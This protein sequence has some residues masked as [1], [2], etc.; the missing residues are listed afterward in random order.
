MSDQW[1][2]PPIV[3]GD[4]DTPAACGLPVFSSP[5]S[6]S[7]KEYVFVQ[8]WMCSRKAF[9]FT[10]LDTPH[11]SASQLPDYSA[12]VL[13]EEGPRGDMGGGMVK[14]NR[15][16]AIVP[17]SHDE[18]ESYSYHFIGFE[19]FSGIFVGRSRLSRIVVSRVAHDY[20][21]APGGNPSSVE[22]LSE[23]RY[24]ADQPGE[25]PSSASDID[26]LSNFGY[27]AA[28]HGTTPNLTTY[29]AWMATGVELIAESSHLSR[30]K[31]N[32]YQRQ[33][34]YVLAQ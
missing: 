31:G 8:E 32:I 19:T 4:L 5:I 21:F 7:T 24:V 2:D 14:W 15:T 12:Y 17:D 11:P 1:P 10:P 28:P 9:A 33:T 20:F 25:D 16:Y 34:R 27:A 6:A 29:Q 13:V 22:I 30:W 3:D 18:Y 26:F 23:T